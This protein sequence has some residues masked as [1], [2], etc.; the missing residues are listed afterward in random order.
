MF[1]AERQILKKLLKKLLK[2]EKIELPI[3]EIDSLRLINNLETYIEVLKT[4]DIKNTDGREEV[5]PFD[6]L[7]YLVD[8][9]FECTCVEVH[10]H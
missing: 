3:K 7:I 9:P 1:L 4:K 8:E 10:G 5:S 6:P 2:N